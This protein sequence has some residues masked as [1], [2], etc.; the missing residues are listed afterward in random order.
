M[1]QNVITQLKKIKNKLS[2]LPHKLIF[3]LHGAKICHEKQ[4]DTPH[5]EITRKQLHQCNNNL[6]K[7][8]IF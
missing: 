1:T 2:R 7:F 4:N 5:Y 8:T 6:P 3:L